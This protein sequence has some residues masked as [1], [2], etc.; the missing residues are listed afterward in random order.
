MSDF[1]TRELCVRGLVQWGIRAPELERVATNRFTIKGRPGLLVVISWPARPIEEVR[2]ETRA[3][4]ALEGRRLPAPKVLPTPGDDF[5][6]VD[7]RA[8][9][10]FEVP[11]EGKSRAPST[12][13]CFQAGQLLA[14]LHAVWRAPQEICFDVERR[15]AALHLTSFR[16]VLAPLNAKLA[17]RIH[18]LRDVAAKIVGD[19]AMMGGF[20]HGRFD[21][22]AVTFDKHTLFGVQHFHR[23]RPAEVKGELAYALA[24][25]SDD[26]KHDG[27]LGAFLAGYD[28]QTPL[29]VARELQSRGHLERAVL[30][31]EE[32]ADTSID[33]AEEDLDPLRAL[34]L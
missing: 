19:E 4:R 25:F 10:L 24:T 3:L 28:P 34:L 5:A 2:R 33:L 26:Q 1:G 23:A 6:V 7:N 13:D 22:R 21:P 30:L 12:E 20:I 29:S 32:H 11:T 17:E 14:K 16:S 31:L 9:Q 18:T 15:L 27:K 8:L